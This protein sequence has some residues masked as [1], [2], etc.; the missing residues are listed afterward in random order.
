MAIILTEVL[1]D[2]PLSHTLASDLLAH[3]KIKGIY[4]SE[5]LI[6]THTASSEEEWKK[7]VEKFIVHY[8]NAK[9]SYL[10]SLKNISYNYSVVN[11]LKTEDFFETR[12]S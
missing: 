8:E 5:F 9:I 11:V 12:I 4:A 7:E 3:I 2:Y 6:N 10:D 1:Q